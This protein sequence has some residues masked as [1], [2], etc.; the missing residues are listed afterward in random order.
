MHEQLDAELEDLRKLEKSEE[1]KTKTMTEQI[2]DD[3]Q[4][5]NKTKRNFLYCG[6]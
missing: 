3:C 4:V 6:N 5:K 2:Y 1:A